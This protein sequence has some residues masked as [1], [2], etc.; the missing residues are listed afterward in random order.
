MVFF[1]N[2][3]GSTRARRGRYEPCEQIYAETS[4]SSR[5]DDRRTTGWRKWINGIFLAK[6]KLVWWMSHGGRTR[7]TVVTGEPK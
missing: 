3:F 4:I 6:K 5:A 2:F 7:S 1:R